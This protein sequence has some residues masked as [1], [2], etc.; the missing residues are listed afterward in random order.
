M[1]NWAEWTTSEFPWQRRVYTNQTVI[2]VVNV[3]IIA[4]LL[5]KANSK[6]KSSDTKLTK[7]SHK[8]VRETLFIW[9]QSSTKTL[10]LGNG[11]LQVSLQHYECSSHLFEKM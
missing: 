8:V 5:Y 10:S 11:S 4:I 7:Q 9:T 6:A 1:K 3:G 2:S